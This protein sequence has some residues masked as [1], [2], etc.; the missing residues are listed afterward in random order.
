MLRTR[1]L[2][3]LSIMGWKKIKLELYTD[4]LICNSRFSTAPGLSTMIEGDISHGQMT[5]F[6]SS[7]AL[8]SKDLWRQVK[9]TVRQIAIWR[10][11]SDKSPRSTKNGGKSRS[12][13]YHKN[14][15]RGWQSHQPTWSL[16]R[17][18]TSSCRSMRCSSWNV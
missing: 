8:T 16:P 14:L 7:K 3:R 5:H 11:T 18:T 12:S 6:L 15:T 1:S 17:T 9:A 13:I 2:K 4:Y 10:A